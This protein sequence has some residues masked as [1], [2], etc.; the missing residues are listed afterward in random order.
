[1][2]PEVNGQRLASKSKRNNKHSVLLHQIILHNERIP[3]FVSSQGIIPLP[4]RDG[5]FY[6]KKYK[7]SGYFP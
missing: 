3:S 7:F 4:N 1:M 6:R 2:T 5:L